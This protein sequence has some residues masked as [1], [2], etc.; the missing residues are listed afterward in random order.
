MSAREEA[1]ERQYA[2]LMALWKWHG[3][4]HRRKRWATGSRTA[5]ATRTTATTT[6][7]CDSK[8]NK[9]ASPQCA[10]PFCHCF[11]FR[12]DRQ[13]LQTRG[14]ALEGRTTCTLERCRQTCLRRRLRLRAAEA[15]ASWKATLD[16]YRA[17]RHCS[18]LSRL[19]CTCS[20]PILRT[21]GCMAV[22]AACA[23]EATLVTT[24]D[25]HAGSAAAA[26]GSVCFCNNWGRKSSR[27]LQAVFLLLYDNF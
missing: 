11:H 18:R 24:S 23:R 6:V 22:P 21:F 19:H 8:A 17:P 7:S 20:L 25:E 1:H 2:Q 4:Q 26:R 12:V 16:C 9:I 14:C 15:A 27:S 5:Y 13:Q 3:S 10:Q